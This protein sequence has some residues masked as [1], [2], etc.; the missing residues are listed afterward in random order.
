MNR[1]LYLVFVVLLSGCMYM[2]TVNRK[3]LDEQY[4]KKT[5]VEKKLAELQK[6]HVA[7]LTKNSQ[8]LSESKDKVIAAQ[9][10]QIQEA[11]NALYS[12]QQA[13]GV[14]PQP[15]SFEFTKDR[16]S[17]G[18]A[19][20]G[21]PPTVKEI[22]E[23]GQRLKD[24]LTKYKEGNVAEI[25]KLRAEHERLVA[26]KGIL[27]KQAE[28]AKKEVQKVVEEKAKIETKYVAETTQQQNQLNKINDEVIKKERERAD[29]EKKRSDEAAAIERAK[30]QLMLWCGI[31][32][33]VA[34]VGAIYSPVGKGG[35]A[36]IAGI[37]AAVT[38][39]IPFVQGWMI[40]TGAGILM[41][42]ALLLIL[43]K[44]KISETANENIVNAIED[45]KQ[46]SGA[47][48]DDLK[49][50]LREWNTKYVKTKAGA[51]VTKTDEEVESYIQEKLMKTG[52][53]TT[54]PK[55]EP[56]K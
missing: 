41:A 20:L 35:L 40:L 56:T 14:Y 22:M 53:L 25:A 44:F 47:T 36:M 21:R 4:T 16:A 43:K 39:A 34:M 28:E 8:Q 27:V 51:I 55:V 19:G 45:T 54:S 24:Y 5:E 3:E 1:L 10:N 33:A 37:L 38:V 29:L 23:G 6:A 31:G 42:V 30:R 17:E 32:A 18:F 15:G 13:V 26:E 11:A 50:N 9:E 52:R 2:P 46:K 48:I 49:N 7:D 12:V